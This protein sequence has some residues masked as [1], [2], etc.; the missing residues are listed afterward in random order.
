MDGSRARAFIDSLSN[1]F[2]AATGGKTAKN[3]SAKS[4]LSNTPPAP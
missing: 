3:G 2:F 4:S 1:R